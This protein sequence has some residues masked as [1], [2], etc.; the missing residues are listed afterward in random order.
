MCDDDKN[1]DV[2][3]VA[4]LINGNQLVYEKNI[5]GNTSF[6]TNVEECTKALMRVEG[7]KVVA[8]QDEVQ[9]L[10]R[11]STF[12]LLCA[13]FVLCTKKRMFAYKG[14]LPTNDEVQKYLNGITFVD[15]YHI[16][17]YVERL[18]V[19]CPNVFNQ[20]GSQDRNK[21]SKATTTTTVEVHVSFSV[22][23]ATIT[24]SVQDDQDLALICHTISGEDDMPLLNFFQET[25]QILQSGKHQQNMK[26]E[27]Q[28][29]LNIKEKQIQKSKSY[30]SG[31]CNES[32]MKELLDQEEKEKNMQSKN[33][34]R[35]ARKAANK[36]SKAN[37]NL[38]QKARQ[39]AIAWMNA[40]FATAL[41]D[42]MTIIY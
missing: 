5:P 22:W 1:K 36:E 17:R 25:V 18:A 10:N 28:Q 9:H 41:A 30:I 24:C 38:E 31:P 34:K 32:V 11:I 4:T 13:I 2:R 16:I 26:K 39:D 3:V 12:T 37:K 6:V 14:D 8:Q 21:V 40:R 19:S 35:K 27:K 23:I 42:P 29:V 7:I 33:S 20:E 15:C